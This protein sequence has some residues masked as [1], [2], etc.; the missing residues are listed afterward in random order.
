MCKNPP[1]VKYASKDRKSW[2]E[3]I[4]SLMKQ[5]C[6]P[7][8]KRMEIIRAVDQTA[9]ETD[10]DG[11]LYLRA[12]SKFKAAEFFLQNSDLKQQKQN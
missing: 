9:K 2:D 8:A 7:Y 6:V 10:T 5:F 4:D 11:V 1:K 12:H 3:R